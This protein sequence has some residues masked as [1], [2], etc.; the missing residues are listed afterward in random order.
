MKDTGRGFGCE[1][2]GGAQG[3]GAG[4]HEEYEELAVPKREVPELE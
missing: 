1:S 2:R 3:S 4:A